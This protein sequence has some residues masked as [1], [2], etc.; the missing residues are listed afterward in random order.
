MSQQIL[1]LADT[2]I[3][4]KSRALPRKVFELLNECSLI[5]HAGDVLVQPV[6]DELSKF[7]PVYA[8]RG[9]NDVNLH[10]PQQLQ[11]K[12]EKISIGLIHDSG[13]T[14][15]RAKR[16]RKLFAAERVVV[17]GHSHVPCN[18]DDGD[19]LLFNPGSPTDKRMQ[20]FPTVG[21]LTIDGQ[22]VSGRIIALTS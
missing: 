10:L 6:L 3:P 8:V 13:K 16:M 19:L 9:N 17:F 14:E 4:K 12:V 20:P 5:V 7:A 18:I 2:H 21:L 11:F 22:H 15:G 1:V